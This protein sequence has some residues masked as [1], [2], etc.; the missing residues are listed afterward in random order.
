LP[1]TDVGSIAEE[2][3]REIDGESLVEMAI[4]W[5]PEL[6]FDPSFAVDFDDL[7]EDFPDEFRQYA[8]DFDGAEFYRLV[9]EYADMTEGEV[10]TL[11]VS[12]GAEAA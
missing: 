11:F 2:V 12:P 10:Y 1:V 9:A 8:A 3:A 5:H 7:P 6:E 4:Q